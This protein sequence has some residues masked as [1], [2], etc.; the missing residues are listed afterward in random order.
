MVKK[1]QV[2]TRRY[3]AT[4]P[5]P[6][7]IIRTSLTREEG[8]AKTVLVLDQLF[9]LCCKTIS[10]IYHKLCNLISRWLGSSASLWD[11]RELRKGD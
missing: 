5:P 2:L 6:L 8:W 3:W 1:I 10:L 11:G 9:Y 4:V 7:P